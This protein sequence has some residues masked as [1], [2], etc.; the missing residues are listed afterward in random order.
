[1]AIYYDYDYNYSYNSNPETAT[2]GTAAAVSTSALPPP[3]AATTALDREDKSPLNLL[4]YAAS[5]VTDESVSSISSA[6]TGKSELNEIDRSPQ[7]SR[8]LVVV[9]P[10][11][12]PA[13]ISHDPKPPPAP[14]IP[15]LGGIPQARTHRSTPPPPVITASPE[16]APTTIPMASTPPTR[17]EARPTSSIPH[18]PPPSTTGPPVALPSTSIPL[19]PPSTATG[20]PITLP[21]NQIPKHSGVLGI[22][23]QFSPSA[24]AFTI[25]VSSGMEIMLPTTHPHSFSGTTFGVP[26]AHRGV[27]DVLH[28]VPPP[29]PIPSHVEKDASAIKAKRKRIK[30]KLKYHYVSMKRWEAHRYI[31]ALAQGSA[32][33][34]HPGGPWTGIPARGPV[35]DHHRF[36]GAVPMRAPRPIS[37]PSMVSIHQPPVASLGMVP[38]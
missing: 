11:T 1:M 2:Q 33:P 30:Y 19:H 20:P 3:A 7:D 4:S 31:E 38:Y 22:F 14:E 35:F 27:G 24:S 9:P 28:R 6:P 32:P 13:S 34:H 15:A 17:Y 8:T 10:T 25:P 29:L 12:L 37:A 5:A 23:P 21:P 18:H 36:P 26:H 16:T